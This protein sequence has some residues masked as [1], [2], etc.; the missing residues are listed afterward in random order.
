[1]ANP[2]QYIQ[3]YSLRTHTVLD[4]TPVTEMVYIHSKLIIVDDQKAIIGSANINDRSMMGTRDSEI[5][6]NFGHQSFF[7]S[8]TF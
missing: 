7:A 2:Y 8:I 1:M 3:F 5:A 4:A 6:V